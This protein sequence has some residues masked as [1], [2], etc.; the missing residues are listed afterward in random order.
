LAILSCP[1]CSQKLRVPDGRK[2]TVTC[3]H[4]RAEWFHPEIIELS[5]VE[6]RCSKSGARF[7]IISSRRSPL[8]K[9]V[10][11]A[12]N[13]AAPKATPPTQAETP[14]SSAQLAVKATPALPG[15]GPKI[16]SWLAGLIR[17]KS[18][19]L[20]APMTLEVEEKDRSSGAHT[21]AALY[22]AD[23]YNWS[24]FVCPYCDASSFVSCAGGHL[25]CDGTIQIRNGGRFHQCFCGY[26]AFIVGTIKTLESN[27]LSVEVEA[28]SPRA[29]PAERGGQKSKTADVVLSPPQNDVPTKR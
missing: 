6:F 25:A 23:E 4:C 3:P 22:P 9:F 5:D 17:G 10:I 2:G 16:A 29:S 20:P 21:A 12:T 26:A 13:R 7:N 14:S 15:A 8:H 11:Q 27:R 28:G 18:A 19:D 1:G 24:G